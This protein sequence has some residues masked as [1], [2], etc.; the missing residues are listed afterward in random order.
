VAAM[1][2]RKVSVA[3]EDPRHDKAEARYFGLV[4][5]KLDDMGAPNSGEL[6]HNSEAFASGQYRARVPADTTAAVIWHQHCGKG[7]K[8]T[9]CV[10]EC[11]CETSPAE[12]AAA[13]PPGGETLASTSTERP[14][15]EGEPDYVLLY[16]KTGATRPYA[17]LSMAI[18]EARALSKPAA[19]GGEVTVVQRRG[20]HTVEVG[21]SKDG[22]Y[23]VFS[24]EARDSAPAAAAETSTASVCK[25]FTSLAR[26][27]DALRAC[28]AMHKGPL[29][30]DRDIFEFL[31]KQMG[32][33]DQEQ[34]VVLGLDLHRQLRSYTLVAKGQRDRVSV[35]VVDVLRAVIADGPH[36]FIV[37]HNHPSGQ[38]SPSKKDRVLTDDIRAGAK[39]ACPGVVFLD[40]IIVGRDSWYSFTDGKEKKR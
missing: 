8:E 2:T 4:R 36:G 35:E 11:P 16:G 21:R 5:R 1:A 34:F 39:T 3:Y 18:A 32:K 40:H 15:L 31:S 13:C 28:Q 20:A 19:F 7:Q 26:D 17:L 33:E 14:F 30:T 24:S 12:S 38:A 9:P 27:E 6:L 37:A 25:P 10:A 22:V 29:E 23:T